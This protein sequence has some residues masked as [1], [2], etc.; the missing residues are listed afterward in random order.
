MADFFPSDEER[1][2]L[3]T[4][5]ADVRWWVLQEDGT[6]PFD[7]LR[8]RPADAQANHGDEFMPWFNTTPHLHDAAHDWPWSVHACGTRESVRAMQ[9]AM[10]ARVR[11]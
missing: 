8:D 2:L 7:L 9:L 3:V 11:A 1:N 6:T 10:L 5:G 4:T